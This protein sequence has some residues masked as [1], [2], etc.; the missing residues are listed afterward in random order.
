MYNIGQSGI[1][2]FLALRS[3]DSAKSTQFHITTRGH[4]SKKVVAMNGVT[5]ANVYA[6]VKCD[7]KWMRNKFKIKSDQCGFTLTPSTDGKFEF[8]LT[9]K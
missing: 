6:L 4:Y 3:Q 7:E 1:F 8:L 5:E 2:E 9:L